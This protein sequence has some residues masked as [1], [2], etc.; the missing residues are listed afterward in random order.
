MARLLHG[1]PLAEK[2]KAELHPRVAALAERSVRPQLK[3]VSVG[4]DPAAVAVTPDGATAY[5]V[6]QT[7]GTVTPID[8]ATSTAGTP[9]AVGS[10]PAAIAITPDGATAYVANAADDTVT[11]IGKPQTNRPDLDSAPECD[12]NQRSFLG[13]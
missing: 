12:T 13:R 8:T 11:P 6:N 4:A 7:D 3:I 2:I 1:R 9:V 5:V 10:G